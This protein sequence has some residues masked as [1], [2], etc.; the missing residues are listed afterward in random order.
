MIALW[1]RE[2]AIV[3]HYFSEALETL[4]GGNLSELLDGE[5][6]EPK[7][8]VPTDG[9]EVLRVRFAQVEERA[10][11]CYREERL[12]DVFSE[13]RGAPLPAYTLMLRKAASLAV[14]AGLAVKQQRAE[15]VA[16]RAVEGIRVI[17]ELARQVENA[18]Q[19]EAA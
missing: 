18:W 12:R 2:L 17:D 6:L 10:K 19:T 7:I 16:L 8:Q 14:S 4:Q 9:W 13:W 15:R 11:I 3:R 1:Q 5:D